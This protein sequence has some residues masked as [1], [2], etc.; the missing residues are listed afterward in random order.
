MQLTMT[1]VTD[2]ANWLRVTSGHL[3]LSI[4]D[5][6]ADVYERP[7]SVEWE[8]THNSNV[9]ASRY[10]VNVRAAKSEAETLIRALHATSG[11]R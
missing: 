5:Y 2:R 3:V 10:A 6:T 4:L 7:E 9:I 8:V 1:D 11:D